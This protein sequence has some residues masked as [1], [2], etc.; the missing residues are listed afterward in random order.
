L[1]Q[2][3]IITFIIFLSLNSHQYTIA[4]QHKCRPLAELID[5]ATLGSS[6][7]KIVNT[8]KLISPK[9]KKLTK[10]IYGTYC[11]ID[12][13]TVFLG[14]FVFFNGKLATT[15]ALVSSNNKKLIDEEFNKAKKDLDESNITDKPHCP[16]VDFC[17][18]KYY[19]L[20]Y[21]IGIGRVH[22]KIEDEEFS[23]FNI[24]RRQDLLIKNSNVSKSEF[25][26]EMRNSLDK[27]YLELPS[28]HPIRNF[29]D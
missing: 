4:S 27:L 26:N 17:I 9:P 2:L 10:H 19:E 15:N 6:Q 24:T 7:E 28:N 5:N 22:R 12:N 23:V 25:K 20:D 13:E 8:F 1:R 3:T 29:L 18:Y 21:S 11:E 16:T 14:T